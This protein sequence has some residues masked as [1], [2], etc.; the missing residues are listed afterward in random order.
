VIF[1]GRRQLSKSEARLKVILDSLT[2]GVITIDERGRILEF[3]AAAGSIFGYRTAEVL[4]KNIKMLMPDAVAAQHDG[5][6]QAYRDT[7]E[8]KIIGIGREVIGRRK[9]GSE[10]PLELGVSEIRFGDQRAFSGLVRDISQRKE[11]ESELEGHRQHLEE[12]IAER[13]T[14]LDKVESFGRIGH[15]W[16]DFAE[17]RDSFWSETM[18]HTLGLDPHSVTPSYE[19]FLEV[20]HPDD[21]DMV[22]ATID[23]N[24]IEMNASFSFG[25]RILLSSGE[26]RFI[27]QRGELLRDENGVLQRIN[28]IAQ[29]VTELHQAQEELSQSEKHYHSLVDNIPGAVYRC[30]MDEHWTARYVSDYIEKITGYPASDFIDNKVRSLTSILHPD[31]ITRIEE[32]VRDSLGSDGN[33]E[34]EYRFI[35]REGN[36]RWMFER[37]QIVYGAG[38]EVEHLDGLILD[39]TDRVEAEQALRKINRELDDRIDERTTELSQ[40]RKVAISLMRDAERQKQRAE[41]KAQLIQLLHQTAVNANQARDADDALKSCIDAVCRFNSWPVGHVYRCSPDAPDTMLPTDIWHLDEP[42]RFATF[43]QVTGE[44]TFERGVGLPGLVLESGKPAWIADITKDANFPHARMADDIG[45]KEGFGVPVLVGDEVVAVLE[46]FSAEPIKPDEDSQAVLDNIG[47]QVGRVIERKQ[48]EEALRESEER[49]KAILN[50]SFQLQG[51]LKRDGTLIEANKAALSMI[52]DDREDVVGKLFWECPWWTHNPDLQERLRNAVKQAA[53]GETVQFLADHE[54]SIGLRHIDVRIS[55]VRDENGEVVFLVPEGHDITELKQIE[56][57]LRLARDQAEAATNM[58]SAFLATMS[59]EIRTPLNGIVGM[60]DLLDQTRLDSEQQKL[61]GVAKE[62]AF[63]LLQIINDILDFSKIE[64]GQMDLESTP[65]CWS[66]MV[67]AVADV[68]SANLLQN[69]LYLYCLVDASTPEWVL[70]DSM[71]LRQIM[72]NL[73]GNAI[74]FTETSAE[75][76]GE[77]QVVVRVE[78]SD[79]GDRLCVEISDNGIGM[80]QQQ[81]DQLFQP[82]TQAD[83]TTHRRFGGTGLGLSICA[84]LAELMGGEIGCSSKEGEG[85]TFRVLLPC[86][87]AKAPSGQPSEVDLSKLNVL[88]LS[89]QKIVGAFLKADLQARGAVVTKSADPKKTG[90]AEKAD[91]VLLDGGWPLKKKASIYQ[92]LIRIDSL[93]ADRI[94]VLVGQ[95]ESAADE[96]YA[97]SQVVADNPFQPSEIRRAIATAVGRVSAEISEYAEDRQGETELPTLDEAEGDGTLILIVEDNPTNQEVI[98]RQINLFGYVAELA[99][100]GIEALDCLDR[101]KFGLVLTDCHMPE[102]DGYEL[103]GAIRERE[104]GGSS[105]LPVVAITAG[106]MQEEEARCLAAGMDDFVSKPIELKI[107][108]RTLHR[109]LPKRAVADD[110]LSKGKRKKEGKTNSDAVIDHALMERYLGGDKEIQAQFLERFVTQNE[111]VIETAM[112][113]VSEKAWA[114]VSAQAHKLKSSALSVGAKTLSS[115]CAELERAGK[116]DDA[117]LVENLSIRLRDEYDRVCE[118]V[119]RVG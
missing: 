55:P 113:A 98:E 75:A 44:T 119:K 64:A 47:T 45:I 82:F 99:E 114:D 103:V 21:R 94:V 116:R 19:A 49:A 20:V 38:D 53:Q 24:L 35:N 70:G 81:V 89:K 41:K 60:I 50:T 13:T 61:A 51:L 100:N 95:D 79:A 83:N 85:S 9:D 27:Q 88:L 31:D 15:W 26:I 1:S 92:S 8:A 97:G 25:H 36:S 109:W 91:L 32:V 33:Y 74:K 28:G 101:R 72:M 80:N 5:Y 63:T 37:G 46:F 40:S 3:S 76:Q 30:D 77:I 22:A 42:E 43:R 6:L 93:R 54:T 104:L 65:V 10:F 96:E 87:P 86:N 84:R 14:L 112:N 4:G 67:E 59:H 110:K 39:I 12:I 17:G 69:R 118:Y 73:I 62:S 23:K 48:A 108:K 56:E 78:K 106:I 111:T 66:Q 90:V 57:K 68:L 11:I 107:I 34:I 16:R 71:R 117:E 18:Y 105:R 52:E 2:V 115:L 7:G 58:K 102:M 29:D